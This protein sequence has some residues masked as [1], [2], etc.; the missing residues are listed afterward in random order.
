MKPTR[1]QTCWFSGSFLLAAIPLLTGVLSA[2][3]RAAN[4]VSNFWYESTVSNDG[5][6]ALDLLAELN[7]DSTQAGAPIAVVMHPYS[8][9]NGLIASVRGRAQRLRDKGFFAISVA[10]RGRDGSDGMRDS[11]GLEIYDIYDAVEAVKANSQFESLIDPTNVHITGYSGGGGNTMSALTKFPDYF[12]A[13]GAFFGMSDYGFDPVDGWYNNGAGGRTSQLDID[14]GGNPNTD[15]PDVVDRYH[16]RASN[17]ASK[18]NPYGQIHLFVNDDETISPKINDISYRDNAIAAAEF[19]GEFDNITVHIGMPGTY[20]DFDGS[21]TNDPDEEQNWPHQMPTPNQQDSAEQW[22]VGGLLDGS[23]PQPVLNPSDELFVAGF[24]KTRPFELWLGDGQNAA[25]ELNYTIAANVMTFE[26]EILSNDLS[27]TGKLSVDASD[28]NGAFVNVHLNGEFLESAITPGDVYVYEGLAHN[29][30]L[31]V[32]LLPK[33]DLNFDG[34]IDALDHG[35]FAAGLHTD[36]SALSAT[37]AYAMGDLNG[38]GFN[39]VHDFVQFQTIYDRVHG[40]GALA[41][42]QQVAVPEAST[43]SLFFVA[44]VSFLASK[45]QSRIPATRL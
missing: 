25:G 21:G 15:G 5:G 40:T 35:L 3:V 37:D 33:G 9:S 6:G 19:P 42:L 18:N 12:R 4:V 26:L 32:E 34:N 29:D 27:K 30:T 41:A 38:D 2:E 14:V 45:Q 43:L 44:L 13:G 31:Q 8:G 24:V 7:Y 22:Y 11:G 28:T 39:N 1:L 20:F 16:A 17:L 10:M 23:I 36:L